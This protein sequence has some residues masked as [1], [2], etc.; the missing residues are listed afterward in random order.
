MD[1]LKETDLMTARYRRAERLMQGFWTS[2]IVPNST[3][4]PIWIDDSDCF[5]YEREIDINKSLVTGNESHG[6]LKKCNKEYRLVNSSCATNDT[7]FDHVM[8]AKTLSKATDQH[9]TS[10]WLPI[11][12]V[13][14]ELDKFF[15]VKQ[16]SFSAFDKDWVFDVISEELLCVSE[17]T[18]LGYSLE[19]PD[20]Q[21]VIFRRNYNLW[22]LDKSNGEERPLTNDGE[23]FYCYAVTGNGWGFDMPDLWPDIQA[24]W[25]NDSRR[26]LTIQ[27]DCRQVTPLHIV[28]HVPQDGSI[29]PKLHSV[30][31]SLQGDEHIPEYRLVAIDVE[32][33]HV[34]PANYHQIPIVRNSWGFFSSRLGWWS[35]DNRHAYFIDLTRDYRCVRVV[36][37]DTDLGSTR[38]LFQET[39]K[40]HLNLM[41]NADE[42]PVFSVIPE[43]DELIWF[44]E[45]T[46]WAHLYL[47]D[48]KTGCLK[49]AVTQ[50]NY[51]VRDIL[52][53]D[54]CRRELY[55]QTAGRSD[56]GSEDVGV[57]DPYYRDLVRVNIDTGE[58]ITVISGDFDCATIS[59]V[60]WEFNKGMALMAAGRDIAD[61]QSISPSGNYAVAAITR[62]DSLPS[63]ILVS[64]E[65]D[66]VLEI[67]STDLSVLH[68]VVTDKW[69]FPERVQLTA[70]DGKTVIYG[71]VY[72]PS[73]FD[74]NRSYPIINHT[75][76][77]PDMPWVPKGSFT[78]DGRYG[79]TF[80]DAAAL[81]E[82]G[83]IVVQIDGRGTPYRSKA[84]QDESYG[85][86]ESASFIEDHISGIRELAVRYPYMDL[87]RVGIY[88]LVGGTGAV[89]GL[90]Q[91]PDFYKVGVTAMLHD[92]RLF[93]GPMWGEKYEGP[94]GPSGDRRYPEEMVERLKGKLFLV[95]GMMDANTLPAN[96]F[97]LVEAMQRANKDFDM[98]LLPNLGHGFNSYIVRKFWDYL[99]V[100]LKGSTPPNGFRLKTALDVI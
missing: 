25:S 50:G 24:R 86:A 70:A 5:W 43:T 27:R 78:H 97:R 9:V 21:L 45:R 3:V 83:F 34:Q 19:S 75:F 15:K 98:L 92:A 51:V 44:S 60:N 47:Y 58:L 73:D 81:A 74:P 94:Y 55:L 69:R 31:T 40:T 71:L 52:L 72:R 77:Q 36:E 82:L 4:Y 53:V 33:G 42:F 61:S 57:K 17:D 14:M 66:Q 93:P 29:R 54:A 85:W 99:V 48:L 6:P 95:G 28:E 96:I 100:N 39:S 87:D 16:M 65:G 13:R 49:N 63:N 30:R 23:E 62:A 84:F 89:Q 32:T 67:E 59:R 64:R 91:Y 76:N 46:G 35:N 79:R 80:H 1:D 90:L 68:E 26:I 20:G 2:N 22:L 88:C 56:V 41:L 11:T 7:A 18:S 37:F 8:L 12:Q 38:I 10:D